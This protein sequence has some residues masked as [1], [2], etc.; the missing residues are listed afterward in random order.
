M[1][2]R[3]TEQI[4]P[5]EVGSSEQSVN[6]KTQLWG[7]RGK[8]ERSQFFDGWR[9]VNVPS[10]PVC[11]SSVQNI[12]RESSRSWQIFGSIPATG[13]VENGAARTTSC[14]E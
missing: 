10:V 1:S 3:S 4:S 9:S 11:F 7:N 13:L 5:L 8:T 6:P 14:Y 12:W 2:E